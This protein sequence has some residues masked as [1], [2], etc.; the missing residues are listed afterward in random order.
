MYLPGACNPRIITY[1][2][3]Q[4]YFTVYNF[5]HRVFSQ[6]GDLAGKTAKPHRGRGFYQHMGK[7]TRDGYN[8]A[9]AGYD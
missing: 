8:L 7:V 5:H 3:Q 1:Y 9:L 2:I 4:I 6:Y